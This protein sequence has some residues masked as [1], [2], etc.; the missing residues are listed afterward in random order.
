MRASLTAG[1]YRYALCALAPPRPQPPSPL[2]P[3]RHSPPPRPR[4]RLSQ[5]CLIFD[6]RINQ[7]Y[8]ITAPLP[9]GTVA[10]DQFSPLYSP[11]W[12]FAAPDLVVDPQAGRVGQLRIDLH[13]IVRSSI[14]KACLLQFLLA[15]THCADVIL[16]VFGKS[17]NEQEELPTLARMFD[18]VHAAYARQLLIRHAVVSAPA[19]GGASPAFKGGD[20]PSTTSSV[21]SSASMGGTSFSSSVAQLSSPAQQQPSSPS[22]PSAS[23]ADA[24][25][26]T[27]TITDWMTATSLSDPFVPNMVGDR[28]QAIGAGGGSDANAVAGSGASANGSAA[29]ASVASAFGTTLRA[30]PPG[31]PASFAPLAPP[32]D[33]QPPLYPNADKP[34]PLAPT[35]PEG[36]PDSTA[37]FERVFTPMVKGQS[38]PP[39]ARCPRRQYA[40]A[41][42]TEFLLSQQQ[43]SL[44][45]NADIGTLALVL[46]GEQGSFYQMHQLVQFMLVPDSIELAMRLL[47]F[48]PKYPPAA[49]LAIDMLKRLGPGAVETLMECLMRRGLLL[50]ACRLL[51][52]QRMVLYPARRLLQAAFESGD[53]TLFAAVYTHFEQRNEVWRG[54]KPFQ[55]LCAACKCSPRLPLLSPQVW[56][57]SKAFAPEE[58]CAEF[59]AKFEELFGPPSTI[60]YGPLR[61]DRESAQTQPLQSQSL[62]PSIAGPTAFEDGEVA[63]ATTGEVTSPGTVAA[64]ADGADAGRGES[65]GQLA[66]SGWGLTEPNPSDSLD[67]DAMASSP[68]TA[69]DLASAS[70]APSLTPADPPS[71]AA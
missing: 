70:I 1:P 23:A 65:N 28:A 42:I 40:I 8:P 10:S 61:M 4:L 32:F 56:R 41:V 49:E 14:D 27:A 67:D 13:T 5:V 37:F 44:P 55:V 3:P 12:T 6:L 39:N 19:L 31:A 64:K 57:G 62:L 34:D 54:S 35:L 33:N 46:L 45:T 47:S 43:H 22:T 7:Q 11:H 53:A 36:P 60:A 21:G 38:T 52:S 29:A 25:S 26:P 71:E 24:T 18:L 63:G 50:A 69:A 20:R 30:P 48:E 59:V 15:R 17:I 2:T 51:R 9:L 16:D 58:G 68:D 66:E